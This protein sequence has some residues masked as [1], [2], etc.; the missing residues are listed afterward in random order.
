MILNTSDKTILLSSVCSE[1]VVQG[2]SAVHKSFKE[3]KQHKRNSLL[4]DLINISGKLQANL[5]QDQHPSSFYT[6]GFT[7][8]IAI[9][10]LCGTAHL[11]NI[12]GKKSLLHCIFFWASTS[13]YSLP[14]CPAGDTSAINTS[15]PSKTHSK[16]KS[17]PFLLE[18]KPLNLI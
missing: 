5:V 4:S 7:H 9:Y 15:K 11:L 17:Y 10:M 8:P 18:I 6:I 12:L 14:P 16:W 13:C 1:K 3:K 2:I